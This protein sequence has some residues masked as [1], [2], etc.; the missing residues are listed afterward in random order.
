[1]IT[2]TYTSGVT[3]N[4]D[5]TIVSAY[6]VTMNTLSVIGAP[7][8]YSKT[9]NISSYAPGLYNVIVRTANEEKNIQFL[10]L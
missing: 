10:K 5:I 2:L 8:N 9:F 6:G 7:F 3:E 1:M 4:I